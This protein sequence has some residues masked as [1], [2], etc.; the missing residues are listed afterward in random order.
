MKYLKR[1]N[2]NFQYDNLIKENVNISL[3][4]ILKKRG[5]LNHLKGSKNYL[6]F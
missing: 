2:E 4:D 6:E 1:F 3:A 5:D